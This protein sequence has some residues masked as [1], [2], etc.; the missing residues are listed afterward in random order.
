MA[1]EAAKGTMKR[2]ANPA[3]EQSPPK[4]RLVLLMGYAL[5]DSSSSESGNMSMLKSVLLLL[6]RDLPV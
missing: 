5:A 1:L 3:W 6:R 2:P 4:R